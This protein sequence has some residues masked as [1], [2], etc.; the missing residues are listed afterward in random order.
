[1]SAWLPDWTGRPVVIVASGPS[2]KDAPLALTK[3]RAAVIAIKASWE[4]APWCDLVYGC[5]FAWWRSVHGLPAFGGIK[6][7]YDPALRSTFPDINLVR[8]EPHNHKLDLT[9]GGRVASG[10]N[11]GFQALAIALQ[12]GA[13]RIAL[14]GF[15]MRVE[16]GREHWYGRNRWYG[17]NNPDQ[18]NFVR[19]V[20]AYAAAVPDLRAAGAEVINTSAASALTC[21]PKMDLAR[22]LER[23][24]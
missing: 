7:G 17:A 19:W 20:K 11:S 9:P 16:H 10:G 24:T 8:I 15:D 22:V 18:H 12:A 13:R 21:F 3:D 5:D 4:L 2:A 6:V 1:M 14:V 23:W